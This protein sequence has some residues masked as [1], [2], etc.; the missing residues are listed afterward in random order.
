MAHV[1]EY[2]RTNQKVAEFNNLGGTVY[3][4]WRHRNGHTYILAGSAITEFGADNKK[5]HATNVVGLSGWGGF[6][7]LPSGNFLV[8]YY[9]G[10]KYAEV[11]KD[12]KIIWEHTTNAGATQLDPTRI[13]RNGNTVVAGGN[14]AFVI[15]YDCDKKE[16]WKVATKGRPFSVR[17]Y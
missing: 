7:I 5:V 10:K 11:D 2:S 14:V 12:G 1:V 8:A 13:Q 9:G 3:Q 16:V 6:E 15:E 17:R 4:A